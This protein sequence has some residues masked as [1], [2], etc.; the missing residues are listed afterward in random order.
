MAINSEHTCAGWRPRGAAPSCWMCRSTS[1]RICHRGWRR[2]RR[3]PGGR[4]CGGCTSC[5]CRTT[6]RR[7]GPSAS[8]RRSAVASPPCIPPSRTRLASRV[9]Y[10]HCSMLHVACRLVCRTVGQIINRSSEPRTPNERPWPHRRAPSSPPGVL[11]RWPSS[12][13]WLRGASQRRARR[14]RAPPMRWPR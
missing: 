4:P 13:R 12:R 14:R 8:C 6:S 1:T 10:Q 5:G 3:R 11:W 9:P 2:R 7:P